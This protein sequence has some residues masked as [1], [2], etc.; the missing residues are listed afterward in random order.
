MVH[1]PISVGNVIRFILFSGLLYPA[2]EL[3]LTW[4]YKE[5][6]RKRVLEGRALKFKELWASPWMP[7]SKYTAKRDKR[8]VL[9]IGLILIISSLS[10]EFAFD[11]ISVPITAEHELIMRTEVQEIV[12]RLERSKTGKLE[13]PSRLIRLT[14]YMRDLEVRSVEDF[15]AGGIEGQQAAVRW[16]KEDI[17]IRCPQESRGELYADQP[18]L[19]A[20]PS[21]KLLVRLAE[22]S[23]TRVGYRLCREEQL[24]SGA[25]AEEASARIEALRS[26][27][28]NANRGITR[29]SGKEKLVYRSNAGS[30]CISRFAT[31]REEVCVWDITG[32]IVVTLHRLRN[33][34]EGSTVGVV[35]ATFETGSSEVVTENAAM[36]LFL[37]ESYALTGSPGALSFYALRDSVLLAIRRASALESTFV[38][39]AHFDGTFRSE[40]AESS[41]RVHVGS[42]IVASFKWWMYLP[43]SAL[44][45]VNVSILIWA[46]VTRMG[47]VK[48]LNKSGR[49][50]KLFE[51]LNDHLEVSGTADYVMRLWSDDVSMA[52]KCYAPEESD[53]GICLTSCGL[54]DHITLSTEPVAVSSKQIKGKR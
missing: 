33:G 18:T 14:E 43:A 32:S 3:L 16:K 46:I 15:T 35:V 45:A 31:S 51:R 25:D 28:S 37:S 22:A 7:H 49:E 50:A 19:A 40:L 44:V 42:K 54:N 26:A 20:D 8:I 13:W 23:G 38:G 1:V 41:E 52:G 12:T 24:T 10:L 21:Y 9:L 34:K 48:L 36:Y 2:V 6:C 30:Y 5:S 39:E 4:V 47:T 29:V 27:M 11:S 53:A 17:T